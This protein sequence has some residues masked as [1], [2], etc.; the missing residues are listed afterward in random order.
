MRDWVEMALVVTLVRDASDMR[1]S[2]D[3]SGG[4]KAAGSPELNEL[5]IEHDRVACLL[6][7]RVCLLLLLNLAE[8]LAKA[9]RLP[10]RGMI[11]LA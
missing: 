5:A 1:D 4:L 8:E 9:A 2:R 7:V 10:M 3:S 11:L 6:L